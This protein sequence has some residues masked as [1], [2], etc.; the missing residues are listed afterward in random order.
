MGLMAVLGFLSLTLAAVPRDPWERIK[1]TTG[2]PFG[3][4]GFRLFSSPSRHGRRV[5]H[6]SGRHPVVP[7]LCLFWPG[8]YPLLLPKGGLYFPY[9]PGTSPLWGYWRVTPIAERTNPSGDCL[10]PCLAA[11]C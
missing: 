7:P 3:P 10:R 11:A 2:P 6:D 8:S 1:R 5:P 9:S 4:D